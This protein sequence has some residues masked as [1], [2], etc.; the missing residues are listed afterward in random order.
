MPATEFHG[1]SAHLMEPA[2]IP[3]ICRAIQN[4][5]S[6]P[7]LIAQ[8]LFVDNRGVK[9]KSTLFMENNIILVQFTS[10]Q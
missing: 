1:H 5:Q 8:S 7:V 10:V 2:E 3:K 4:P 6:N 9:I